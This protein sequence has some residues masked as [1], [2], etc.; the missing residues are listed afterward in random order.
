MEET[1]QLPNPRKLTDTEEQEARRVF[2]STIDYPSISVIEGVAW[3]D[4]IAHIGSKLSGS[5][6]P[7][8]NA[9]TLGNR[10]YFPVKLRTDL[11]ITDPIFLNDMSWLVHEL[12]HT[13]QYQHHGPVYL[14]QALWAQIRLG[15]EA[16]GYGWD[17]G[18]RQAALDGKSLLDFNR[19]QQGDIAR[20][21]YFRERQGLDTS[22][23][24]PFV[25]QFKTA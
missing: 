24:E 22:A 18:L 15:A 4:T 20:H 5:G 17:Q 9:I 3:P 14:I 16:Y 1:S 21:Y 23:W 10:V 7:S 12:T 19:E 13:W 25:L 2:S 8:H 11:P 6:P